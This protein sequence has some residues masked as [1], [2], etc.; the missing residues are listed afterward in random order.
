MA[1]KTHVNVTLDEGLVRWIDMDR[2]Q[3]PRST[4]IN[5]ILGQLAQKKMKA[6]DWADE[7][8]EAEK[9]VTAGRVKR[10]KSAGEA[11]AWLKS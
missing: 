9:D 4:F 2:G 8:A 3:M 11:L 5:L 7:S 10:C 1:I 6:F